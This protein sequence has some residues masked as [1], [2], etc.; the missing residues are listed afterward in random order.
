MNNNG[1]HLLLVRSLRFLGEVT[2]IIV[3]LTNANRTNE[4]SLRMTGR[5]G[6]HVS[7]FVSV[8]VGQHHGSFG[9]QSVSDFWHILHRTH[10]VVF[11]QIVVDT[12][13][14]SH[15]LRITSLIVPVPARR[16]RGVVH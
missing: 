2:V 11:P 7:D 12:T 15:A 9:S 1:T 8:M 14:T 5:K 4:K 13:P 3:A 16:Y 10:V 6:I